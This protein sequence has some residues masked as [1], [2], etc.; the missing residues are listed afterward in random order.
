MALKLPSIKKE[1]S[2]ISSMGILGGE[3][4][5][6]PLGH[7]Y[8]SFVAQNVKES[9]FDYRT[10]DSNL[11][12]R[13]M[14]LNLDFGVL[15]DEVLIEVGARLGATNLGRLSAQVFDISWPDML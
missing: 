14:W 12:L 10:L 9:C 11:S 15:G 4:Q 2:F 7:Y 1:D 6:V 13:Q 3:N 5:T 8:P